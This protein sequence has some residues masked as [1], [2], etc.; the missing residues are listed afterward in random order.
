MTLWGS[1]LRFVLA[2]CTL[3]PRLSQPCTRMNSL[4]SA[5]WWKG[6]Y[7]YFVALRR[8]CRPILAVGSCPAFI[9]LHQRFCSP[10]SE[11]VAL[12]QPQQGIYLLT[13]LSV[14]RTTRWSWGFVRADIICLFWQWKAWHTFHKLTQNVYSP[15]SRLMALLHPQQDFIM[16]GW[17]LRYCKAYA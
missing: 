9:H 1:H 15:V 16:R 14:A 6:G 17:V 8:Y 12:F 4:A 13:D 3:I 5:L 11:V 2:M 7:Q 10:V